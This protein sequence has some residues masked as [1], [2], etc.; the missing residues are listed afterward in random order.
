MTPKQIAFELREVADWIEGGKV[1]T[2]YSVSRAWKISHSVQA[3]TAA[4]VEV[5]T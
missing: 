1:M 5:Q 3:L 2:S 4:L